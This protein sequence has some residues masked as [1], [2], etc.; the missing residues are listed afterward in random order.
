MDEATLSQRLHTSLLPVTHALV[1]YWW[2]NTR[3][4]PHLLVITAT[5]AT[6]C[7]KPGSSGG[8]RLPCPLRTAREIFTSSRS[9]LSNA[10][11][12]TQQHL[13]VLP[14]QYALGAVARCPTF[15]ANQWRA[16]SQTR[17]RVRQLAKN[18][19]SLLS[20]CVPSLDG[21]PNSLVMR[22]LMEVCSL[23]VLT[24]TGFA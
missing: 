6:S 17:V 11:V 24:R 19:S 5:Y 10:P 16:T 1:G 12:R 13:P 15:C 20:S 7:R 18:L 4:C 22:H 3:L 2:Q 21:L 14:S 23:P 9:S 8:L